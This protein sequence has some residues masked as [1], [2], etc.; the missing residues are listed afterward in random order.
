MYSLLILAV[1]SFLAALLLTPLVRNLFR[2]LGL[3]DQPDNLRKLHRQPIPRIGGIPI[4]AAYVLA[5]SVLLATELQ[6]GHVVRSYVP[7]AWRLLPA[8]AV[9][10]LTGLLDDLH[11]ILPWQKLAGQAV[12]AS[13]AVWAGIRIEGLDGIHL[14]PWLGIPVTV[15]W[16]VACSN[17]FNL[18]DGVD[19]LAAGVGLFATVT[20]LVAGLLYG[21]MEIAFATAPLAG[22]L[23]GFIRFNFNP[24]TVFL[25]DSGSLTVGF[26][27][28]CFAVLWSQKS[29]TLLG[30]VAPLMAL[31][32]PLLDTSLAI[33]R[34]FLRFRPIFGADRG[35]IH[36]RLLDR[37]LTPRRVALLLYGIT[38]LCAVL[39]LLASIHRS[40]YAGLVIVLFCAATWIGV[41]HLGYTEFGV[42]GRM[43]LD[44]AFRRNLNAQIALDAFDAR[45]AAAPS[46]EACWDA[47]R[48]AFREFG[49]THA[50]LDLAG[51]SSEDPVLGDLEGAWSIFIPLSD[52][53]HLGLTRDFAC[54]V[55]P[56]QAAVFADRAASLLRRKAREF[57]QPPPRSP[58]LR[59]ESL[60]FT[61]PALPAESRTSSQQH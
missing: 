38:G 48:A 23:A 21:N 39:S 19:G 40:Q 24:A 55:P 2:R 31:A 41:Q 6:G 35:H 59:G 5:I 17:A 15:L 51:F 61:T 60:R 10:F 8:V 13:L 37:G 27:L 26:L 36:H 7:I 20:T 25:G 44:G 54:P 33:A 57:S 12:A 22:A 50:E 18:I 29:A 53:G 49:F 30:M 14:T 42:A 45:L 32:V 4:L 47:V 34:R 3:C 11:D 43:F 46:P 28:G 1:A 58:G 56:T 9:V 52:D 16:L